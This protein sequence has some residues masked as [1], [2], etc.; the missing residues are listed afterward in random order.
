MT[1]GKLEAD[2]GER[3]DATQ[4]TRPYVGPGLDCRLNSYSFPFLYETSDLRPH[5]LLPPTGKP[6]SASAAS[7]P[8]RPSLAGAGF[9]FG[10][11]SF[12]TVLRG[13]GYRR[14]VYGLS[15]AQSGDLLL[16]RDQAGTAQAWSL[17]I[18]LKPQPAA[19]NAPRAWQVEHATKLNLS[20]ASYSVRVFPTAL[21]AGYTLEVWSK[22]KPGKR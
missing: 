9:W 4:L 1:N 21:R 18:A 22:A 7:A 3:F 5:H 13:D 20:P 10:A 19:A 8:P 2:N 17:V 14:L 11:E 12:A 6:A 15:E 16:I